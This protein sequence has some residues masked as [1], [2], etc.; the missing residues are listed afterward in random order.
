[1]HLAKKNSSQCTFSKEPDCIYSIS[2]FCYKYKI[3]Q[4]RLSNLHKCESQ[5]LVFE[6]FSG[7]RTSHDEHIMSRVVFGQR[8]AN[9]C[10]CLNT[11]YVFPPS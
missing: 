6:A 10:A 11:T 2:L 8:V 9:A 5:T 7:E 3:Q 4:V 1:M